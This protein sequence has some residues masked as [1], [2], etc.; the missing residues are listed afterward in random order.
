MV[1]TLVAAIAPMAAPN[2]AHAVP[3]HVIGQ[4]RF[5]PGDD[6]LPVS[7][8][9]APGETFTIVNLDTDSHSV[10]SDTG[11]FDTGFIAGGTMASFTLPSEPGVYRYHCRTHGAMHG[12]ITIA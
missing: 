8:T 6:R 10:T 2:G 9:A 11:A 4:S 3:A 7:D 5:L 12:T 1:V